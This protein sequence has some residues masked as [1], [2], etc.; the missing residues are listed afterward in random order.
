MINKNLRYLSIV[1]KRILFILTGLISGATI[2]LLVYYNLTGF[3]P[4]ALPFTILSIGS[5][6]LGLG[7]QTLLFRIS[8]LINRKVPWQQQFG[9]RFGLEFSINGLIS[10][11]L[12]VASLSIVLITIA[13][14]E[15]AMLWE[16][17]WQ[18]Y[19][20][21]VILILVFV[22]IYTIIMLLFYA[23]YHFA[24]GQ[25]GELKVERKQIKLQFEALKSQ[26]SPHYL[27]NSLNTISSLL[28]QDKDAAEEFI[29]RLAET[30]H[31]ILGTHKKQLVLL[32]E[33]INF[34]KAYYYLL[35]VRY[36]E[37]LNLQIN[38]PDSLY[39]SF[40]PPMTLQILVENAIKHN[41]FSIDEPLTIILSAEDDKLLEVSNNKTQQPLNVKSTRIGLKNIELRYKYFTASKIRV[42]NDD[43]FK[44]SVPVIEQDKKPV[45]A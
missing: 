42:L 10:I 16:T 8:D 34:V 26:L 19:L 18:S 35:C 23:Q 27:F 45:A 41:T 33:E 28:Y 39:S 17:Y 24:E 22:I 29:R 43:N 44:V 31:Y 14:I 4:P 36:K 11:I 12:S 9:L 6:L 7:I 3:F 30:Y 25:I 1:E 38:I 37:G 21:L 20:F 13:G 5:G 15:P 2:G 40:I 32:S